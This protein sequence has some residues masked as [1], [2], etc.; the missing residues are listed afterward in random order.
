M[1]KLRIALGVL[2]TVGAMALTGCASSPDL[3]GLESEL[4]TV[5]GVNGS[6]VYTTHSGAPWNTQVEV[7]LF[8]DESSEPGLVDAVREAAPLILDD[9]GASGHDVNFSFIAAQRSDIDELSGAWRYALTVTDTMRAALGARDTGSKSL[10]LTTDE[11][12]AVADGA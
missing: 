8:M 9:P 7:L 1:K 10:R 12:R 6:I 2:V 4:G 3:T 11:L 5:S